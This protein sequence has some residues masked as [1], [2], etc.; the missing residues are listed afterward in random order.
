[1]IL[2]LTTISPQ[3]APRLRTSLQAVLLVSLTLGVVAPSVAAP[4]GCKAGY[5][6][7]MVLADVAFATVARDAMP[8]RVTTK[9]PIVVKCTGAAGAP[10][11]YRWTMT[12]RTLSF[13]MVRGSTPKS[14]VSAVGGRF[15]LS[16]NVLEVTDG[17]VG[18]APKYQA[19]TTT[20]ADLT[21]L[22]ANLSAGQYLLRELIDVSQE[23][24]QTKGKKLQC[25]S[26][27]VIG[28]Y[29]A[30]Y[31][32]N[33]VETLTVPVTPPSSGTGITVP[34]PATGAGTGTTAPR[35]GPTPNP[36]TVRGYAA[37]HRCAIC[38]E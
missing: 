16:T 20:T 26:D 32:L 33:V 9:A 35:K 10:A 8:S 31:M 21:G 19:E 14:V 24:C 22:S 23:T 18:Y 38:D 29:S 4:D 5:P 13:T 30:N 34:P 12:P 2:P 27:G 1:M 11:L 37:K 3:P 6:D 25:K 15:S 7:P 17:V 36:W 28:Q